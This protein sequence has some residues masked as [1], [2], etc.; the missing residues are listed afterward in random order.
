MHDF[1]CCFITESP[2][3]YLSLFAILEF[4]ECDDRVCEEIVIVDDLILEMDETLSFTLNRTD[5][6]DP[7]ITLDP[8]R[9]DIVIVDNDGRL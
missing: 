1:C 9:G 4:G 6:L 5:N 2:S 8:T 7:R 3:D